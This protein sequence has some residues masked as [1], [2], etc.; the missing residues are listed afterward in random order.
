MTDYVNEWLSGTEY[1]VNRSERLLRCQFIFFVW[2]ILP[3]F[4]K[5]SHRESHNTSDTLETGSPGRWL[6]LM[7][8]GLKETEWT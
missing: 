6:I 2:V 4:H 3:S 8:E 1:N 5:E 7:E